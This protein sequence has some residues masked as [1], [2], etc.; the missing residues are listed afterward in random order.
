[1]FTGIVEESGRVLRLEETEEAW[2]L[3][4]SA[5]Q[6]QEDLAVGDSLSVNGCCLTV[7]DFDSTTITCELLNETLRL[8]SFQEL[9]ALEVL[10]K[11]ASDLTARASYRAV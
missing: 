1:M 8:T 5:R 11:A 4:V 6:I 10:D 9:T 3:T 2:R 7:I